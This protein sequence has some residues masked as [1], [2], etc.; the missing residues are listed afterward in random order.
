MGE[1]RAAKADKDLRAS[2]LLAQKA[3]EISSLRSSLT[4][5]LNELDGINKQITTAD[6]HDS[7]VELTTIK[8][9]NTQINEQ[10]TALGAIRDSLKTN[11]EGLKSQLTKC[12]QKGEQAQAD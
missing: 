3:G 7:N 9:Q 11:L 10:K 1:N 2:N 4:I 5:K 12:T 6:D 8:A